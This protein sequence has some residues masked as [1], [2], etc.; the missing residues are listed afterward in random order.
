MRLPYP[1]DDRFARLSSDLE[2][3]RT[4]SLL[5]HHQRACSHSRLVPDVTNPQANEIASAQ[6]AVDSE[7]EERK[8]SDP[9][10]ELQASSNGPNIPNP[11]GRLL[12]YQLPF[13]PSRPNVC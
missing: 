12:A 8:I 3:N 6:L 7:I 4:T 1:S 9:F 5:L 13:V 2:L 10:E 11:Q